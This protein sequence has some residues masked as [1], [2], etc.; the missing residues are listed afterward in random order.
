MY[1]LFY[2]FYVDVFENVDTGF[3]LKFIVCFALMLW[4]FD[5]ALYIMRMIYD[6]FAR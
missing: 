2:S 5:F 1:N 6:M 4:V 3:S